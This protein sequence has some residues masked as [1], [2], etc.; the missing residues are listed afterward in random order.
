MDI[1]KLVSGIALGSL[2]SISPGYAFRPEEPPLLEESPSSLTEEERA[3]STEIL[4]NIV[5][6]RFPHPQSRYACRS[7]H[8]YEFCVAQIT[9]P[10]GRYVI[11]ARSSGE[12]G[13]TPSQVSI[14]NLGFGT[15]QRLGKHN[16]IGIYDLRQDRLTF[17][18]PT[19]FDRDMATVLN[20]YA[21]LLMP[22]EG[23]EQLQEL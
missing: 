13:T 6:N 14:F 10:E 7:S 9:L 16:L 17:G 1:G 2:L 20:A 4:A 11:G 23:E 8:N 15:E 18:N 22:L 5:L 3:L 21:P 12:G 19:T